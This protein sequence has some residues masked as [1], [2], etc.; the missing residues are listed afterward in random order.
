M[1]EMTLEQELAERILFHKCV[2][3]REFMKHYYDD[4]QNTGVTIPEFLQEDKTPD[5]QAQEYVADLVLKDDNQKTFNEKYEKVWQQ[6]AP[7][8]D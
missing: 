5:E 4:L 2:V 8:L 1:M 7:F 6:I 3:L